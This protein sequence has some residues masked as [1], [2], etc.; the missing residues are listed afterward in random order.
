MFKQLTT[1]I[2]F[3]NAEFINT[4]VGRDLLQVFEKHFP[5]VDFFVPYASHAGGGKIDPVILPRKFD[6]AFFRPV[7]AVVLPNAVR[8]VFHSFEKD[9]YQVLPQEML[10]LE[11]VRRVALGF[12]Q[13]RLQAFEILLINEAQCLLAQD[14]LL[15]RFAVLEN[16]D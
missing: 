3:F 1:G 14:V 15:I 9:L 2:F 5:D 12:D 7:L 4:G 6:V 10:G 13:R 8:R 16:C 11:A